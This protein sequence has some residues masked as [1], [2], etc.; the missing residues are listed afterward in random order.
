M[1]ARSPE[2]RAFS[3]IKQMAE[4]IRTLARAHPE[5]G[6]VSLEF[7]MCFSEGDGLV[8]VDVAAC[9]CL[10][11]VPGDIVCAN[12][13][14]DDFAPAGFP[15]FDFLRLALEPFIVGAG[16]VHVYPV[17]EGIVVRLREPC[18]VERSHDDCSLE[19]TSAM[20]EGAAREGLLAEYCYPCPDMRELAVKIYRAME[21]VRVQGLLG[22]GVG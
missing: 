5:D 12:I 13:N 10:A 4:A 19:V 8:D 21:R 6:P 17:L 3:V 18:D 1:N 22:E 15:A 16:W 2:G 20:I 14:W 9:P 7:A 11:T